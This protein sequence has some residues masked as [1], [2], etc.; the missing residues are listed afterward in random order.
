[1]ITARRGLRA[2]AEAVLAAWNDA[3]ARQARLPDAIA[4][5]RT[6]LDGKL[7]RPARD[8]TQPPKPREGTKQQQVLAMLRRPEGT[9][10]A[11]IAEA[12]GWAPHTVR[13]FLAGLPK[14]GV[15]V[16]V[17]ERVRRAEPGKAG[18]KGS[19]TVYRAGDRA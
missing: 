9:T 12:T 17:L 2:A 5:L 1:M 14:R 13:G 11:Q 19:Y 8:P 7:T 6:V 16:A 18:A 15:S 10:V 4:A 3:K